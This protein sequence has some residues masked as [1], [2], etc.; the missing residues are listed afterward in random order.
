M[1]VH[2]TVLCCDCRLPVF[3]Q[4]L[5]WLLV[6]TRREV[7][8][9]WLGGGAFVLLGLLT[10]ALCCG[11]FEEHS[12]RGERGGGG[13]QVQALPTAVNCRPCPARAVVVGAGSEVQEDDVEEVGWRCI[14]PPF[15][16]TASFVLLQRLWW[17]LS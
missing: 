16:V 17:Q 11:G 3:F 10:A 9:R 14:L 2:F 5:C 7:T 4:L 8:C 15:S 13:L 12:A 1:Q 6:A